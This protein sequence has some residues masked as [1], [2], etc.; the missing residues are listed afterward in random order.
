MKLQLSHG[1]NCWSVAQM[2]GHG[3][4]IQAQ[5]GSITKPKLDTKIVEAPCVVPGQNVNIRRS[6]VESTG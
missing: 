5:R 2:E 4:K 3:V 6:M 1:M